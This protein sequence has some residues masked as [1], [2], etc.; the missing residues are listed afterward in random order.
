MIKNYKKKSYISLHTLN[1]K[2]K[3]RNTAQKS[4]KTD[5]GYRNLFIY[6]RQVIFL[7]QIYQNTL[8]FIA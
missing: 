5:K 2:I 8:L 6:N 7:I 3:Y 1:G 4:R